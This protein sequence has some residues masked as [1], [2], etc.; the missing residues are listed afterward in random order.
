MRFDRNLVVIG[1]GSATLVSAYIAA[2]TKARVTLVE[3]GAMGG[4]CLNDGC[5]PSKGPDPKRAA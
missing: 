5:V 1:A 3:Q 2:A 4:A